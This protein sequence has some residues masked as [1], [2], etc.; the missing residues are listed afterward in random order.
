[1]KRITLHIG[2]Y[3]SGKTEYS[4]N[5]VKKLADQGKKAVLVDLDIVNPYFRSGEH[6]KD[7][8]KL[9]IKVIKP[10]FE[11]STVAVPSLPASY[12]YRIASPRA[13]ES[14]S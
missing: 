4:L 9:G 10:N 2:H 5:K 13:P 14:L 12:K 3:G 7:L 11:G 1:M 8:N 6:E